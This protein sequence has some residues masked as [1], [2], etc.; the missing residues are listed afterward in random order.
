MQ[1]NTGTVITALLAVLAIVFAILVLTGNGKIGTLN[2]EKDD[3]N[4]QVE[5]LTAD[6][7][8]AAEEAAAKPTVT[9][10]SA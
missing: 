5:T 10:S 4:A 3:L 2:K 7:A 8:K 6:A 1:K 9:G